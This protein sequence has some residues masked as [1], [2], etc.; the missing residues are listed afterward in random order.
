MTVCFLRGSFLLA[1]CGVVGCA[2]HHAYPPSQVYVAPTPVYAP[3]ATVPAYTAAPAPVYASR[4]AVPASVAA[5]AYA[6]SAQPVAPASSMSLKY[7]R[8][9]QSATNRQVR[10][11]AEQMELA[12][13]D[14]F[15]SNERDYPGVWN[16][17]MRL[18]T[19]V[20]VSD[21]RMEALR[22]RYRMAGSDP[23]S[24]A[25]CRELRNRVNSLRGELTALEG[26]MKAEYLAIS[27]SEAAG[28]PAPAPSRALLAKTRQIE[29][30]VSP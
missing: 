20:A 10:E 8:L 16:A 14:Y 6:P 12:Y 29:G 22:S 15:K 26:M 18:K 27:R 24:D 17:R 3:R 11:Q 25:G 2:T 21:R 19:A 1:V 23:E 9:R 7:Q 13:Y 30:M 4:A 28:M 5:P